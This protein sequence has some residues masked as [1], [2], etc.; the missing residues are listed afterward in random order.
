MGLVFPKNWLDRLIGQEVKVFEPDESGATFYD[1][2]NL[3]K[4]ITVKIKK[5]KKLVNSNAV[6]INNKYI[7]SVA[8]LSELYKEKINEF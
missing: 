5:L 6:R 8:L 4:A 1:P 3:D 7:V 2:D